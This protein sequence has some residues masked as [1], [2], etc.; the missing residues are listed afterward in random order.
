MSSE[1]I[2][3]AEIASAVEA[4]CGARAGDRRACVDRLAVAWAAAA[5]GPLG[6]VSMASRLGLTERRVRTAVEALRASGVV[7]VDPVAGVYAASVPEP[8]RRL[9][10][11]VRGGFLVAYLAPVDDE[12]AGLVEERVVGLRDEYML[13]VGGPGL[14]LVGL[15]VDGLR[16]PRVPEEL[17]GRYA[18]AVEGLEGPGVAFLIEAGRPLYFCPASLYALYRVCGGYG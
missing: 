15:V 16:A 13:A 9:S 3:C 12:L 11:G 14:V 6:R 8:L 10:C 7:G 2:G 17:A 18:A 4:V 5:L 1:P